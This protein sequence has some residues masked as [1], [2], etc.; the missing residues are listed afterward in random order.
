MSDDFFGQLCFFTFVT[1]PTGSDRFRDKRVKLATIH[2]RRS[3]C[4][5]NVEQFKTH[6]PQLGRSICAEFS[7]R[8]IL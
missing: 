1:V 7:F 4:E 6:N 3:D 5:A 2:C 8:E